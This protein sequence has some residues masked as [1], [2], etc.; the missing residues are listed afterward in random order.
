MTPIP[1]AMFET[2]KRRVAEVL[3][4]FFLPLTIVNTGA[5]CTLIG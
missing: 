5:A 4:W 1:G 3:A 2:H